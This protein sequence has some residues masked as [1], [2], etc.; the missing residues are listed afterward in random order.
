MLVRIRKSSVEV[1]PPGEFKDGVIK[2]V[3]L[4]ERSATGNGFSVVKN[5]EGENILQG[6]YMPIL[7]S[8]TETHEIVSVVYEPFKK[9]VHGNWAGPEAIA[10]FQESF[11][12]YKLVDENHSFVPIQEGVSVVKSW[13][14]PVDCIIGEETVVA[15]SWVIKMEITDKELWDKVEK[16]EI[17]GVSMAGMAIVDDTTEIPGAEESTSLIA[18]AKNSLKRIF[19]G[20]VLEEYNERVTLK[21]V[22]DNLYKAWWS[23]MEVIDYNGARMTTEGK[24]SAIDD[25][26][27]I[28]EANLLQA[29]T[30]ETVV[31]KNEGGN[32]KM[33]DKEKIEF[34]EEVTTE[35]VAQITKA[36]DSKLEGVTSHIQKSA[37]DK[38]AAEEKGEIEKYSAFAKSKG[39]EVEADGTY[40]ADELAVA[41][42]KGLNYNTEGLGAEV[43]KGI[44][45]AEMG[46]VEEAE[47]VK[48]VKSGDVTN[49]EDE[50]E[51]S[52]I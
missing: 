49:T 21:A 15:D 19:K 16:G 12:E 6:P 48:V 4:V 35:V 47:P 7:K 22:E 26:N 24:Q 29:T 46:K 25:L 38:R 28:L 37:D 51:I 20:E 5:E 39:F 41:I 30:E 14:Q 52:F 34:K 32:G 2:Y 9:D 8:D 50:E 3:S 40:T 43:V 36:I 10:K 11:E 23:F 33:T 17:T 27:K 1:N 45:I 13:I 18:K 44:L 42:V 31:I